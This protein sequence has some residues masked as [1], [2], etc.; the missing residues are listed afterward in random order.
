MTSRQLT[1]PAREGSLRQRVNHGVSHTLTSDGAMTGSL[2]CSYMRLSTR[3]RRWRGI[4]EIDNTHRSRGD[5]AGREPLAAVGLAAA[6]GAESEAEEMEANVV[7]MA[8]RDPFVCG[9]H[10]S[11]RR[12]EA[13]TSSSAVA[14]RVRQTRFVFPNALM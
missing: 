3:S 9:T 7:V 8:G 13:L 6:A 10:S 12:S 2:R 5:S 4:D 14:E 1:V 11:V